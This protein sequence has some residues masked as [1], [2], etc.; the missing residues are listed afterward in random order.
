MKCPCVNCI[1]VPVCRGKTFGILFRDC[2]LLINYI[3]NYR[4]P[5]S[6]SIIRMSTL[7]NSLRPLTWDYDNRSRFMVRFVRGKMLKE[8]LFNEVPM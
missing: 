7:V 8:E 1:C 3:P 6:R 4:V 2:V 5:A